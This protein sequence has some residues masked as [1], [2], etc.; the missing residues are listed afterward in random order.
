MVILTETN[1]ISVMFSEV[2]LVFIP[3]P[4]TEGYLDS[5]WSR[6]STFSAVEGEPG[7]YLGRRFT[8]A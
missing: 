1:K 4:N 5:H 6:A 7:G 2:N 8:G 3:R